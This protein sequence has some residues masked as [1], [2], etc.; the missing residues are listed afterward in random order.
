MIFIRETDAKTGNLRKG[1]VGLHM[2]RW[3]FGAMA[4][5]TGALI[6]IDA[7]DTTG[8]RFEQLSQPG[9]LAVLY[10]SSY[11]PLAWTFNFIIASAVYFSTYFIRTWLGLLLPF[12]GLGLAVVWPVVVGQVL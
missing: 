10:E 1:E 2:L 5:I 9:A 11:Y 7:L 4:L 6:V 3:A 12:W 8:A